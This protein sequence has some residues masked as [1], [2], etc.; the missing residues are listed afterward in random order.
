LIVIGIIVINFFS[1]STCLLLY[2]PPWTIELISISLG[3]TATILLS[4]H[5]IQ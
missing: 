2:M 3:S 5:F 4:E 1:G